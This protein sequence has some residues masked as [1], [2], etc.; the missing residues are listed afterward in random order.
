[1]G[2]PEDS[3]RQAGREAAAKLP[4]PTQESLRELVSRLRVIQAKKAAQ[5]PVAVARREAS[6]QLRAEMRLV[7]ERYLGREITV[8]T[9][10][11]RLLFLEREERNL[12]EQIP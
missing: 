10:Y 7:C 5:E 9:L 11:R 3:L 12:P 6:R 1:M 4:P 8:T 2:D